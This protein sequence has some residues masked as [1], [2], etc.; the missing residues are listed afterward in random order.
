MKKIIVLLS[1]FLFLGFANNVYSQIAVFP[2]E[3]LSKDLNGIDFDLSM[4][5]AEKLSDMNFEVINPIEIADFLNE[6]NTPFVGWVDKIVGKQIGVKFNCNLILL[7]TILEY[8]KN[9]PSFG[10]TI[11][12]LTIND[13]KLIWSNTVYI[14]KSE[15]I[16]FLN[17]KKKSLNELQKNLVE[18]LIRNIPDKVFKKI[19][20]PDIDIEKVFI[21]ERYLKKNDKTFIKIKLNPFI[22]FPDY[23]KIF[24]N[25]KFYKKFSIDKENIKIPIMAPES[26]GRYNVTMEA[27]WTEPYNLKKRSF[28][29]SFFVD[30]KKPELKLGLKHC[31][32][33]NNEFF[34]RN[35]IK[36][37]PVVK[38]ES[39]AHWRLDIK[40][41]KDNN[42]VVVLENFGDLPKSLKWKGKTIKGGY[43][44]NGEYIIK[45]TVWDKA[46][47][48]S[49]IKKTVYVVKSL[50]V[51]KIEG[52]F[53]NGNLM[54]SI[55]F[56]EKIFVPIAF[57]RIELIDDY[58]NLFAYKEGDKLV[59]SLNFSINKSSAKKKLFYNFEIKDII[60]N[61]IFIKKRR[62]KINN[63][64]DEIPL[65]RKKWINDF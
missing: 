64:S 63:S 6:K 57:W 61:R 4:K 25:E 60:G 50:P 7:G 51:F 56:T 20:K 52:S 8:D 58:G 23:I 59:S 17:L 49:E 19:V 27:V 11:R 36:I 42:S 16:S 1:I 5:V 10:V 38:N 21:S 53:E 55:D 26:D 30:N 40:Y 12:L 39:I 29:T 13:Y 43:I 3:D 34:F 41:N 22:V 62:L 47:N 65:K 14:S 33:I 2:F 54:I 46:G 28:L 24:I 37:L 44:S 9:K 45:L 31:I 35:Y 15:E 32:K 48:N 18:K